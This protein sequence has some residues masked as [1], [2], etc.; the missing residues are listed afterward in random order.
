[1]AVA[2]ERAGAGRVG[3]VRQPERVAYLAIQARG[4]A[5]SADDGSSVVWRAMAVQKQV[6][7]SCRTISYGK[8]LPGKPL[9]VASLNSRTD[10]MGGWVRSCSMHG[11]GVG[12]FIDVD[13]SNRRWLY[14]T[15]RYRGKLAETQQ[16]IK[17]RI[18]KH[19]ERVREKIQL[20]KVR[21]E[22]LRR[23]QALKAQTEKWGR[24]KLLGRMLSRRKQKAV[25]RELQ[26]VE[27]TLKSSEPRYQEVAKE[28]IDYPKTIRN[29][30]RFVEFLKFLY[31]AKP[32]DV[33][34][35]MFSK[36]FTAKLL[37]AEEAG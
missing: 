15:R 29:L 32:Q 19:P 17:D 31:P 2:L 30:R 8:F 7:A 33:S 34:V 9:A 1:M 27:E 5:F 10:Q 14:L 35:V 22:L 26:S 12:L 24:W 20:E 4:G 23:R 28:V 16:E 3:A 37:P 21:S 18:V 36:P 6:T 11:R 13:S 25:A